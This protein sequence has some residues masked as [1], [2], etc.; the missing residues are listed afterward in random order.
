MGVCQLRVAAILNKLAKGGLT[1][2]RE[3]EILIYTGEYYR[4]REQPVQRPWG[5]SLACPRRTSRSPV[6]LKQGEQVQK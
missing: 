1:E 6:L 3:L 4:Q 2:L 5:N